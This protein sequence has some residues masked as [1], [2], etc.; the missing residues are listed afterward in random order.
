MIAETR[1]HDQ[2][3]PR[4]PLF[5]FVSTYS[6]H[7]PFTFPA[8][9]DTAAI[10]AAGSGDLESTYR[11]TLSYTDREVGR[12][13]TFLDSRQRRTVTI[14]V[15]DHGFYTDL[16][17]TSGLPE[18]DAVWTAGLMAGP[19]DLVG[20]PRRLATPASHVDMLPTVM[21]LVG[22]ER[23]SA[24]LGADLLGAPRNGVRSAFAIRSGGLRFDRDGYSTMVDA[25][26]PNVGFT[27]VPFPRLLPPGDPPDGV[28]VSAK[29]LTGWVNDWSYFIEHNRVWNDALLAR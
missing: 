7:Y 22:D 9:A 1:R 15:G 27:R 17:R 4:T 13:L 28:S 19:E 21:R 29:R 3:E 16:R 11:R 25:R 10:S 12:L 6:T 8:D 26:V 2:V 20:P 23:P 24:A 14:V 18:N 5:A